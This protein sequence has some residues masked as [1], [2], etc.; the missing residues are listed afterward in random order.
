MTMK[1][2]LL[3]VVTAVISVG[4]FVAPVNAQGTPQKVE[5]AKVTC[6]R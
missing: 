4:F 6:R 3:L 5:I 1:K 2:A